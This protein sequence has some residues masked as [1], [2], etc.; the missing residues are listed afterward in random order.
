MSAWTDLLFK[1]G[2]MMSASAQVIGHRT[3]RHGNPDDE[4]ASGSC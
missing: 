4:L 3:A 1:T 2:E